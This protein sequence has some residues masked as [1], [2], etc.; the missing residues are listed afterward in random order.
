[1]ENVSGGRVLEA[2]V[3]RLHDKR[4]ASALSIQSTAL[5]AVSDFMYARGVTQMMPV[6]ISPITDP[7]NHSVVDARIGYDGKEFALTKSMILHK[8]LALASPH[9]KAIYIVSPNIRLEMPDRAKTGRHLLEFSQVDFELKGASADDVF[10]FTEELFSSVFHRVATERKTELEELGRKICVPKKPF[11][12]KKAPE[13]AEALG[14][15][16]EAVVSREAS[17]P[18]WV[19]DH[20]REFY[21]REDPKSERHYLNYDLIYPEGFGE[22]LS[23]G[24]REWEH[25]RI[26][27]RMKRNKMEFAP[28]K[29][30]LAVAE[31]GLLCKSAGAGFGVERLVRF[32]CGFKDVCEVSP[33]TKKPGQAEYVF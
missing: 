10:A 9:L 12:R 30:Y 1:M 18:F 13:L 2:T 21:D 6:M 11:A 14:P 33:F 19:L 26:V 7:L 28:Y 15:D 23:G 25:E 31:K 3:A 24:E 20:E 17:E 32:L 27:A 4:L 8:Q 16:W 29:H 5:K 22:A